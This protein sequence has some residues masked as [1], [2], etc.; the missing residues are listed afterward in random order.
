MVFSVFFLFYPQRIVGNE[1]KLDSFQHMYRQSDAEN[2]GS[3]HLMVR[4][5]IGSQTDE[6]TDGQ[7]DYI[8]RFFP[9]IGKNR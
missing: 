9:L 5:K 8:R 3:V 2:F 4:E 6:R 7:S 1:P